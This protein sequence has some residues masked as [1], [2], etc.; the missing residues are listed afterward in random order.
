VKLALLTDGLG[1]RSLER[2]LDWIA[3]ELRGVEGIEL[4]VGGYSPVPHCDPLA[5]EADE[6]ARD[7]LLRALAERG[8]ELCAL[9]VSGNPLHPDA[10]VARRHHEELERAI[11]LSASLEVPRLV[12]MSGCP[13]PG[14]GEARAPHFVGGGWLPDL[15]GVL[16]WQWSERVLPYWRE[17]TAEASALHPELRLCFELHPGTCVYNVHTFERIAELGENLAVNLD[18]SHFFWQGIDPLAVVER[19]GDRVGFVHAKDTLERTRNRSLNGVLDCRWPGDPEEMPWN[20]ATVGSGHDRDWW[21]EFVAALAA[22]G[23]D[24]PV[25]IE[26]EDPFVDAEESLRE[27]ASCLRQAM[28]REELPT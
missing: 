5:L 12:V 10:R 19:L 8:L 7:A 13:G 17:R 23:Y 27:A 14:P 1:G 2:A 11:R 20:F 6:A 9:N 21:T 22:A 25:S 24:G 15:E 16:E 26:W 18:P 3:A 4:G 28:A